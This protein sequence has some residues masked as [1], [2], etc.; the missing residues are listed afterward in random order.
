[1]IVLF[2]VNFIQC[3][4]NPYPTAV[5]PEGFCV[6][7][8]ASGIERPRHIESVSNG[9]IIVLEN[10]KNQVIVMWS[11][12]N[13]TS[14][15]NERATLA[16]APG[17]NHGLTIYNNY[18]YASSE[19]TLF[20]WKY[21]E[22]QREYLGDFQVVVQDMP[23]GGHYTRTPQ[24]DQQGNL[25][26]S[27]GSLSN[28]DKNSDRARVNFFTKQQLENIPLQWQASKV[29]ADGLRNE[30]GLRLDKQ[31][32]LWGVMNGMDN[33]YRK[34]LGGD[35]HQTNPAEELSL[36]EKE[37]GYYGYP[38]CW[39]E[40]YIADGK[41][42]GAGTMWAHQDFLAQGGSDEW[43]RTNS[44]RPTLPLQPHT[45]PLDIL[46]YY[47]NSFPAEFQN[48][49]FVTLHGS[50][51]SQKPVGYRVDRIKFSNGLPVSFEPFLRKKGE[52]EQWNFRPV[53][54]TNGK[55]GNHDCLYVSSDNSNNI[56]K[57]TYSK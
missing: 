20:R 15:A 30:V 11:N 56:L 38:K 18:L 39:A 51:N 16:R 6:E 7:E 46:F 17:L 1:L 23:S 21:T 3:C 36:L 25:F 4:T 41:G 40:Y 48:D 27:V 8:W 37:N 12:K 14:G 28:V 53:S 19:T 10:G 47:G 22:G 44:I 13:G 55:C 9:D 31:G 45:A 26:L 24:F 34:D 35:I 57:I 54:V 32:R 5:V 33:L 49:A 42:K 2:L 50:W 29:W 43:C 52:T